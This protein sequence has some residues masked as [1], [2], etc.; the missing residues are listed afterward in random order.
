MTT[1]TAIAQNEVTFIH[2]WETETY[3]NPA[4]V[5]NSGLL[6]VGAAYTVDFSGSSVNPR[7][8][9]VGADM[10]L[11]MLPGGNAVGVSVY[12]HKLGALR[13]QRYAAQY[14]YRFKIG[15]SSLSLGLQGGL[16]TERMTGE[17]TTMDSNSGESTTEGDNYRGEAFDLA[18]GV[19]YSAPNWYVAVSAQHLNS[20][21]VNVADQTDI[22][23]NPAYY[24]T[25]GYSIKLINPFVKIQ[26]SVLL[27]G[28]KRYSRADLSCR[29]TYTASDKSLYGGA[30]YS[31]DHSVTLFAGG[32][33]KGF[34]LGYSYEFHTAGVQKH[35]GSH[36][37]MAGWQT[38][39]K[40]DKKTQHKQKSVRLL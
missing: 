19:Y 18:A 36:G 29:A 37:F 31:P 40:L 4:A 6:N 24:F 10:P 17:A 27:R 25:A 26:P 23:I 32:S 38:D 14:A 28:E 2:Y 35:S 13:H 30:S 15:R 16:L 3:F 11:T 20:P 5:G 8:G 22:K 39:L 33:Y 21:V 34:R 9:Y 7:A 12:D 1:M